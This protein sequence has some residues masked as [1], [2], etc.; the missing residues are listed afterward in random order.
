MSGQLTTVGDGRL[1]SPL[2]GANFV[3]SAPRERN[4]HQPDDVY[5]QKLEQ[6]SF[7]DANT[8]HGPLIGTERASA[9]PDT[10][11]THKNFSLNYDK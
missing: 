2:D 3:D 6:R 7:N 8:R 9:E 11:A 4:T 10:T 5:R 1:V